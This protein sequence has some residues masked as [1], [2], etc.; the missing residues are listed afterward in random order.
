MTPVNNLAVYDAFIVNEPSK[1][2]ALDMDKKRVVGTI[3]GLEAVK[4]AAYLIFRTERF[5]YPIFSWNYGIETRKLIGKP[6]ALVIAESERYIK[7]ALTQDDR[8]TD[9]VDFSFEVDKKKLMVKATVF[10]IFGDFAVE[11]EVSL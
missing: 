2:F 5:Y 3:D 7:E 9:V 1:T 8:I 6:M 11:N 4:Q 10:S